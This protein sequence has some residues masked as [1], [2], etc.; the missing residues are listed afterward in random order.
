MQGLLAPSA[1]LLQEARRAGPVGTLS[2]GLTGLG[3]RGLSAQE[4]EGGAAMQDGVFPALEAGGRLPLGRHDLH[5]L[6]RQ[7][8]LGSPRRSTQSLPCR[9]RCRP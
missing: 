9:P 5:G 7:P 1:V 3:S 6:S 8:P 2:A 4:V